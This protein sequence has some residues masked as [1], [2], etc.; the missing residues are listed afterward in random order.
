MILSNKILFPVGHDKVE[1]YKEGTLLVSDVKEF[2]RQDMILIV[3]LLGEEL[4]H[5]EFWKRRNKLAGE[6]LL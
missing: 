6:K 3:S 4:K 2:I 1:K 5:E